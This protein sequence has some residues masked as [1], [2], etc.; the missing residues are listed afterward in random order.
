MPEQPPLAPPPRTVPTTLAIG[1]RLGGVLPIVGWLMLG[2]GGFLSTV[3]VGNSEFATWIRFATELATTT[4]E[5]VDV[6]QANAKINDR[7]VM[8]VAVAFEVDG[9]DYRARSF[10]DEIVPAVGDEVV[11]E[12]AVA[13]PTVARI[14]GLRSAPFPAL[15]ALTLLF[16]LVA[17]VLLAVAWR[18][19]DR[20]L[21][22]MRNGAAHVAEL[23]DK[24]STRTRVN[25]RM[26]YE[27]T[28]S[29]VDDAGARRSVRDRSHRPEFQDAG[30]PRLVLS[31]PEDGGCVAELIPGRPAVVDGEWRPAPLRSALARM[32][33]PAFAVA[34]LYLASYVELT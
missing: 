14:P 34:M 33:L 1:V 4:G 22:L 6:E 25:H 16:P 5:V 21:W 13:D 32:L 26:V 31:A 17:I 9:H 7:Q 15:V 8:L 11:V 12:Y 28:F 20:R 27:L 2:V 18:Q 23:I 10:A 24:K 29:F 3:F 19:A 30:V